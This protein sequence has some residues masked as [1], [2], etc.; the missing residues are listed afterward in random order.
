MLLQGSRCHVHTPP[1]FDFDSHCSFAPAV[2]S[3]ME[4]VAVKF[5]ASSTLPLPTFL[6]LEQAF[7]SC[8]R[9]VSLL[10]GR[11]RNDRCPRKPA[12]HVTWLM[13]V[14]VIHRPLMQVLPV[15]RHTCPM[16]VSCSFFSVDAPWYGC[17]SPA[18]APSPRFEQFLSFSVRCPPRLAA[19]LDLVTS[20]QHLQKR[21]CHV[22]TAS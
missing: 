3:Q 2:H 12:L 1:V 5:I 8:Q 22:H 14:S 4:N 21:Q 9:H 6:S 11:S 10:C 13:H 7:C 15:W 20:R 19:M 16:S 17:V 18:D